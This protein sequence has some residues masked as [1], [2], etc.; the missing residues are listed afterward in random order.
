M[1]ILLL[2]QF[3]YPDVAPTGQ[4]MLDLAE[5]LAA[6][7]VKVTVVAS[8]SSYA[9]PRC[10][11]PKREAYRGISIY[12]TGATNF[13]RRILWG[14]LL[15]YLSF[16]ATAGL[17]VLRLPRP[18]VVITL[19]TPPWLSLL[20]LLLQAVKGTKW[21]YWVQDIYPDVG[22]AVGILKR[23]S[24]TVRCLRWVS[25][26]SFAKADHV[27]VLSELMARHVLAKGGVKER[28]TIIPNWA[29][30]E[31]IQPIAREANG[32]REYYGLQGRF[33][34]LYSGNM[35]HGHDF[36][37]VLE[38]AKAFREDPL[39]VFVFIGDG[40]KKAAVHAFTDRHGLENIRFLPYQERA[41]LRQSL[42]AG[43]VHL[44]S[45]KEGLEGLI[46]PSKVYGI[47][48]AGRPFIYIGPEHGEI[49]ELIRDARCGFVVRVGDVGSLI[50]AIQT[51]A[52]DETLREEMGRRA[53]SYFER[54]FDRR[55]ATEQFWHLLNGL[56]R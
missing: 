56:I 44:V 26:V 43:D 6:Q 13:G 22:I 34:I 39:I 51:L 31:E 53:R 23:K 2:N 35:G 30:G 54:F 11:F 15:D 24:L 29:D 14:R 52:H 4:L 20:G 18:D 9:S 32:F 1:N 10:T 48:A 16:F 17:K 33:V 46:V 3:F 27:V 8:T 7:G 40:P 19:S 50:G 41:A 12:R 25:T 45:L 5:D 36:S 37:T 49:G 28:I 47:M 55:I 38:S 21:V 42:S